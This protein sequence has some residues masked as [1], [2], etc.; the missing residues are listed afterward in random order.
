MQSL[1][2]ME[3][4]K[5]DQY[6]RNSEGELLS[7]AEDGTR[8]IVKE[9]FADR[10]CDLKDEREVLSAVRALALLHR[11]FRMIKRQET[12]NMRSMISLPLFEAMRRHNRE[13]KK[14]RTFIRGKRKKNEFELRVIGNFEIS[15]PRPWKQ[16]GAW[17]G[18]MRF[19]EKRSQMGTQSAMGSRITTIS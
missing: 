2:G 18:C 11:Q 8:Y 1:D 17:K 5:A 7:T 10:E 4:L 13:L 3:T 9:W 19:T 12:W 6:V 16:S 14:A 15:R